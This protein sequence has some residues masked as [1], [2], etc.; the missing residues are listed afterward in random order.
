MATPSATQSR[1]AS[2][3]PSSDSESPSRAGSG[4]VSA[5]S[6]AIFP[7]ADTTFKPAPYNPPQRAANSTF[8]QPSAAPA[9]APAAASFDMPQSTVPPFDGLFIHP[10]FDSLP[11]NTPLPPEGM[12]YSILHSNP[13]WFLDLRDWIT[14]DSSP[15]SAL[16]YPRDLEP[17]RPRRQKDLLLRC[18]FCPRTYAGVNAKSMW[19]RHVREKHRVILS[20]AWTDTA[21]SA[22]RV[23]IGKSTPAASVGPTDVAPSPVVKK[24]PSTSAPPTSPTTMSVTKPRGKQALSV[25][26]SL[27]S[28]PFPIRKAWSKTQAR[29]PSEKEAY[30]F[31]QD[32][33]PRSEAETCCSTPI[34]VSCATTTAIED[35]RR[36]RTK[37]CVAASA[38][39]DAPTADE[40]GAEELPSESRA[41]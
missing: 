2:P 20:K 22:K 27:D 15:E 12:N 21:T 32:R 37:I 28:Q 18:T 19:T 11:D 41:A 8:R 17:P 6:K 1:A 16:R 25:R 23:S 39:W 29:F 38:D 5:S 26:L 13:R 24:Q 36:S 30:R 9:P 7:T 4:S 3:A 31:W 33:H 10:P 40:G 35:R 14:L 34:S